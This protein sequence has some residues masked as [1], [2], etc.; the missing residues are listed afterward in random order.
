MK[1]DTANHAKHEVVEGAVAAVAGHDKSPDG[2]FRKW[3]HALL[4]IYPRTVRVTA[5]VAMLACLVGHIPVVHSF[6]LPLVQLVGVSYASCV[7]I[8]ESIGDDIL[9]SKVD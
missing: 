1:V 3:M 8:T 6:M 4:D 9:G 7:F 5:I 2:R